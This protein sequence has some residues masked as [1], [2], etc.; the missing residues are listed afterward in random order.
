MVQ[1][2]ILQAFILILIPA[3]AFSQAEITSQIQEIMEERI[4]ETDNE[5]ELAAIYEHLEEVLASPYEI[6]TVSKDQLE[7]LY[8]LSDF[9]I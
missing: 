3:E 9:Q 5:S 1:K 8:L 7:N 2:I 4:N 6:N